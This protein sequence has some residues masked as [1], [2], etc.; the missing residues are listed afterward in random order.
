MEDI[1]KF[2][3]KKGV[4][5]VFPTNKL[6]S[7]WLFDEDTEEEAL[8]AH[9]IG[10]VAEKNGLTQNDLIHLYP[11]ILRMLKSNINWSK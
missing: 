3:Y 2:E 6:V 8:L 4:A 7:N 5:K 9:Y 10:V 11:A 1:L